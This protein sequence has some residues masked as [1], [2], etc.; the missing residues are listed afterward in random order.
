MLVVAGSGTSGEVRG[1]V[2]LADEV[3]FAEITRQIVRDQAPRLFAVVQE[4]GERADL[5]IAAWGME[6]EDH[7]AVVSEDGGT[8]LSLNSAESAVAAFGRQE[9][10]TA[11]VVWVID[12]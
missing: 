4:L 8:R 3:E 10:V 7:A 6:F 1:R 11:K 9:D 12:E 5:R 2:P